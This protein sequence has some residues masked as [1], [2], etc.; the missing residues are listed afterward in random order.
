LRTTSLIIGNSS[1]G[2]I[3]SPIN[4]IPCINIGRRQEGRLRSSNVIDV[5]CRKEAIVRAVH[6]AL[7]NRA[8]Q[9]KVKFCKN[10]YG[11]GHAAKKIEK[12][13][14]QL[15]FGGKILQKGMEF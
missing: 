3:E 1:S 12:I 15:R 6:F 11:D 9:R 8:F 2:I 4:K 10:P 14:S 5:P 13:L 7:H